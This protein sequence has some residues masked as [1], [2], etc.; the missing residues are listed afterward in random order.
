MI[1]VV[2]L[3]VG[4]FHVWTVRS[5]GDPWKFGLEQR[6]YY[7]LL[8][9]GWLD[10]QLHL[11]V[12]VPGALLELKDPYDPTLRPAGLGLH[13]A[14]FFNGRYYLYF[15]AAPVV[16]LMLP[17][18]LWTGIDLPLAVAV[19]VFVYGAFLV[20]VSLLLSLRRRYFPEAGTWTVAMAV[21][22]LGL[23]LAVAACQSD[24][25]Y[26]PMTAAIES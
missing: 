23:V 19:L 25:T 24:Q 14:S 4:W 16:T 6:D 15:G 11:K 7:N 17:F 13:D 26:V 10:G 9:D 18:R 20:S 2:C 5:S 12:E 8:I 22:V 21:M 1:G 3:V